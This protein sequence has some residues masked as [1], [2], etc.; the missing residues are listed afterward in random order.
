MIRLKDV[1]EEKKEE[2]RQRY[3]ETTEPLTSIAE[4]LKMSPP[5]FRRRMIEWGGFI[6]RENA[7]PPMLRSAAAPP[8]EDNTEELDLA[9]RM[10]RAAERDLVAVERVAKRLS[11]GRGQFVE[12]ERVAR[13]LASLTRTLTKIAELRAADAAASPTEDN[14][15]IPTDLDE[16]RRALAARMARL[17][18]DVGVEGRDSGDDAG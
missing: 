18:G 15:D 3:N 8:Q 9:T 12:A 10:Q 17:A 6:P 7:R 4:W 1:S 11:N 14:D 2:A 5:T 16:L 13:T